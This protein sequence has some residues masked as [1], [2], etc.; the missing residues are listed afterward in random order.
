MQN[1]PL[2]GANNVRD[3]GGIETVDGRVIRPYCLLRANHLGGLT[4]EDV[5]ILRAE[6]RVGTVID[7]RIPAEIER[8]PNVEMEGVE[9]Y[10]FP[11]TEAP[12]PG[13]T[14]EADE[15]LYWL[16]DFY[17]AYPLLISEPHARGMLEK[18]FR[19]IFDNDYSRSSVLFHCYGGKDR[20]GITAALALSLLGVDET[21]I[22]ADYLYTN[23][24]GKF[25]AD[26]VAAEARKRG[27]D[28]A[29]I[30]RIYDLCLA[31]LPYIRRAL[32]TLNRDFGGAERY[33]TET[34]GFTA[35]ETERF[36][37]TLLYTPENDSETST[38]A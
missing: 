35:E 28:E 5:Q 34:L 21:G 24:T 22:V 9:S 17:E 6:Y 19:V 2:Q 10:N 30:Q 16:P 4:D 32:D 26:S 14:H 38:E 25:H 20:T 7:L 33:F 18:I 12:L 15:L 13:I 36:R 8:V 31:R 3:L 29:E 27:A 23:V 37:D 1:I 11:L